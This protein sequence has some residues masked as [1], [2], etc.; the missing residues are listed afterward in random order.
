MTRQPLN[1]ALVLLLYAARSFGADG[2][3][4]DHESRFEISLF[5]EQP[6]IV[7]PIGVQVDDRGRLYVI[8]S[9]THF[10]PQEYDGPKADRIL[11]LE[12]TNG[13]Q[14]ADKRTIFHEGFIHA[15]DLALNED[16]SLY[17]AT[18][19][20]VHRLRDKDNDG[21]ADEE[22]KLIDLQTKGNYPHDGLSGLA[23]DRKGGMYFGF[24]ENLGEAYK[25]IGSD[26]TTLAG[27]GEGG[28]VYHCQL[29]G[30]KLRRVATGFWNPFGLCVD[31][32]G[33]VFATDNDPDSSPPCRLLHVIEGGDYGYQF[34]YGRSGLHVFQAWNGELPGTLPMVTGTGEAPC[35]IVPYDG[36]L[37]VASWADNRLEHHT[38]KP[39]GASF[40]ADR[41]ILVS[42]DLNFRPVGIGVAKDGT[43]YVSDWASASYEL[44]SKGRIWKLKPVKDVVPAP[45]LVPMVATNTIQ[46]NA[47]TLASDD[48]FIRSR[49][50]SLLVE[51]RLAH[52]AD[53][54]DQANVDPQ[55]VAVSM[56]IAARRGGV[57]PL[58]TR[59]GNARIFPQVRFLALKWI[60]DE[61][62]LQFRGDVERGLQSPALTRELLAAHLAA[63]ERI[64]GKK[65]GD[66]PD[67]ALL[68]PI[69]KND[70]VSPRVRTFALRMLPPHHPALSIGFL[71]SLFAG[72]DRELRLE[73][74]RT[75]NDSPTPE[76][77]AWLAQLASDENQDADVRAE[78]ASG[79]AGDATF[80]SELLALALGENAS[81]RDEAL[82]SLVEMPLS[83][84]DGKRLVSLQGMP[85]AARLL[86]KSPH[87]PPLDDVAAWLAHT[88]G[89]G[90]AAAGR[91]IFFHSRVGYCSRCHRYDGRGNHVGPDLTRIHERGREWLLT[92][93]IQPARDVAPAYRQ[94]QIVMQDGTTRVGIS[95]RKGSHSEDY[96]GADGKTFAVK[97]AEMESRSEIATSMMPEGLPQTMTAKEL[98][99]V[100]A[101][102]L[103]KSSN[104]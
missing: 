22:V 47:E 77:R 89:D 14:R 45:K 13:D 15:M 42:G 20:A 36:G 30:T 7:N 33:N 66:L 25:L 52:P 32:A 74:L 62:L 58:Y 31:P 94:W 96:L 57:G 21:R 48:P 92:S 75:L 88:A 79:L 83:D 61:R 78:A 29:D 51:Q 76:R 63:L 12:D 101:F 65:I 98:R 44:P 37:L 93:I 54:L 70:K 73:V 46:L 5:A 91:R 8:E 49:A 67:P 100:L 26:G 55:K 23:F 6:Q 9:H 10:R 82:R 95:L 43:L 41:R 80:K 103:S 87:A 102:L 38:L 39:R 24:G 99:D 19:S 17:V 28:N 1:I 16:G 64:D 72:S 2:P 34:R 11:L 4:K 56:F 71:Q 85:E 27:E 53:L 59:S 104:K 90:D 3:L 81:L 86:S 60:A 40:G 69:V 18:R 68:L 50:I 97:L 84:D 35:E